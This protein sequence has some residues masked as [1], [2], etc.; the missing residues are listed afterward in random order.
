[1]SDR[2]L[3]RVSLQTK[4]SNRFRL[5]FLNMVVDAQEEAATPALLGGARLPVNRQLVGEFIARRASCSA[6]EPSRG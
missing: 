3:T 1:M 5:G 4:K 2:P 6:R